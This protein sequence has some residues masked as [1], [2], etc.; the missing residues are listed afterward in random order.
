MK[1]SELFL[2]AKKDKALSAMLVMDRFQMNEEGSTERR[3]FI[4]LCLDIKN[5]YDTMSHT[6]FVETDTEIRY[7]DYSGKSLIKEHTDYSTI[8]HE[9][10][11]GNTNHIL[12]FLKS[13]KKDSEVSFKVVAYNSCESW[14]KAGFVHHSLYGIVNDNYYL[15]SEY[16]GYDN[17][18]SP[19]QLR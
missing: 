15:L 18:A 17:I 3:K 11:Y 13:I 2:K 19:I 16:T 5:P 9:R 10:I 1:V 12:T 8:F 6:S 14:E 7:E 4:R